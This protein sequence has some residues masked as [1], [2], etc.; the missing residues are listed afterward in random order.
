MTCH[1]NP[2]STKSLYSPGEFFWYLTEL[3]S[4]CFSFIPTTGDGVLIVER[5][6][7]KKAVNAW[8]GS[9]HNAAGI[10]QA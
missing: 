7:K 3:F 9:A 4:S 8:R 2:V 10:T 1:V 5:S 6:C